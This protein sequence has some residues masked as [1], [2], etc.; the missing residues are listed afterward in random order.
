MHYNENR[1]KIEIAPSVALLFIQRQRAYALYIT[2]H[3]NIKRFM[4]KSDTY[5][6]ENIKDA[7]ENLVKTKFDNSTY[8]NDEYFKN[9][10]W[11]FYEQIVRAENERLPR[12][13]NKD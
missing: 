3:G 12:P 8:K 11:T 1:C 5:N 6:K 9:N 10:S 13:S 4:S 2:D 7:K